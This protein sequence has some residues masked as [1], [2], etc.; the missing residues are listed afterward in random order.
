MPANTIPGYIMGHRFSDDPAFYDSGSKRFKGLAG[1]GAREDLR[2]TVGNPI[3][4]T[5]NGQRSVKMDNTCHGEFHSPIPWQGS[6]ILVIK[7]IYASGAT[8]TRYPILFG[9]AVTASSNGS[10][11][12]VH[13]SGSR[14]VGVQ[15]ASAQLQGV[16]ARNDNNVV[17]VAF[18]H[19][20]ETRLQY[21]SADGV[22]VTTSAAAASAVNGN[23]V[24]LGSA[25]NGARWGNLSGTAGDTTPLSDVFCNVMEQHFFSENI[26]AGSNLALTAAVMAEL[27]TQYGAS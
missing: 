20:Q 26:L 17:V 2:V 10:V 11:S 7:P 8:L 6:M 12:V 18:S 27:K 14:R 5:I 1:Y 22:T 3:F 24:A 21:K 19:S 13:A 25:Q 9:D 4:E 23:S 16:L 15:T